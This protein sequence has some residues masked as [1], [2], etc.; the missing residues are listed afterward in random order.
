MSDLFFGSAAGSRVPALNSDKP[1]LA[2]QG[3]ETAFRWGTVTVDSTPGPLRIKLDGDD[4]ALPFV[5]DTLIDPLRLIVGA[6]VWV[7]LFNRRVLILG[8]SQ[9]GSA[10]PVSPI[11][12]YWGR[13]T[14]ST[15]YTVVSGTP[16]II[17]WETI[18]NPSGTQGL[19]TFPTW[20]SSGVL[21]PAP[22]VY[23]CEFRTSATEPASNRVGLNFITDGTV[24][25]FEQQWFPT[26][27]NTN[28][29]SLTAFLPCDA[30][31]YITGQFAASGT[32]STSVTAVMTITGPLAG[33]L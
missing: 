9:S 18:G 15:G 31:I 13:L 4:D 25:T 14:R 5:P 17:G 6:R 1:L 20:S 24:R 28:T 16:R 29:H 19:Q 2:P 11:Q 21:T 3:G 27:P 32:D 7:Q 30:G 8:A 10:P 23:A 26:G 12:P 22:G 33:A